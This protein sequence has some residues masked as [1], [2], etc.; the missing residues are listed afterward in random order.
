MGGTQDRKFNFVKKHLHMISHS[1]KRK[2][3]QQR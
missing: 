2:T 3:V 1:L